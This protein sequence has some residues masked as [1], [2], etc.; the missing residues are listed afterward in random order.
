VSDEQIPLLNGGKAQKY[1]RTVNA[2][3]K[4]DREEYGRDQEY[5]E[6]AVD[7]GIRLR[8]NREKV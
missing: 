8:N 6:Q 4:S 3:E 1:D 5:P 2:S 7:P